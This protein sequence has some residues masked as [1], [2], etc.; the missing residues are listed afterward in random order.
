M[1][2]TATLP[3]GPKGL[4]VMGNALQFQRDP[5]RFIRETQQ[6]YGR[7]ATIYIGK[8]P[9]VLFFQPEHVRYLLTENQR[10]FVKPNRGDGANL[11]YLLGDGLLT[12]DGE[13]HRQ[14]RRLVQPAGYKRRVES[15]ANIMVEFTE[16]MLAQWQPGT[17]INIAQAM[18]QLTL[19]IIAKSLFNID[20]PPLIAE[21][22]AAFNAVINNGRSLA[23][24]RMIRLNFPFTKYGKVVS[25]K[26]TLD[27]FVYNLIAERHKD[28]R[29]MGDVLSMLLH[30]QEEGDTLTD[31]Q[32]HDHVLTFVAAGHETAQNTLSWTF[33]LLSQHPDKR[34]K[35]LN[36][37]QT[38]LA[39]RS[40]TVA[41][42]G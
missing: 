34:D 5:L 1:E 38:V 14:Q 39:G 11:R 15:Y 4:P 20:L 23:S 12:I 3:P 8:Q 29:D 32:I 22:G 19:S 7:M 40:P 41:D 27:E 16:E 2:P 31:K 6:T 35:L 30:A 9:L 37:L 26:R 42:L 25:G 21:L 28:E 36:E 17:T 33:Y 10:N 24:R 13:A 18:Q